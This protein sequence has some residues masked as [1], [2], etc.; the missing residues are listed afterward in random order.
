MIG[1]PGPQNLFSRS[2]YERGAMTLQAL[3]TRIGDADFSTLLRSWARVRADG[4]GTTPEFTT[5]AERISGQQLD[6]FFQ[7]WLF[8]GEKPAL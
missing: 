8:T 7:A 5:L 2:V 3:R 1:D 4:N 6:S